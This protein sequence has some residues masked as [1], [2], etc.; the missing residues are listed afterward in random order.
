MTNPRKS[1]RTTASSKQPRG[2]SPTRSA[3][4]SGEEVASEP[5]SPLP[6]K[7]GRSG[8]ALATSTKTTANQGKAKSADREGDLA[9]EDQPSAEQLTICDVVDQIVYFAQNEDEDDYCQSSDSEDDEDD[10]EYSSSK[11]DPSERPPP[12]APVDDSI[13]QDKVTERTADILSFTLSMLQQWANSLTFE[14][15]SNMLLADRASTFT[16]WLLL[17]N[18]SIQMLLEKYLTGIPMAVRA[19][20]AKK[21]K[22]TPSDVA[23]LAE[24]WQADPRPGIYGD[25]PTGEIPSTGMLV[26]LMEAYIGSTSAG[27]KKRCKVHV[28]TSKKRLQDLR[29]DLQRSLHYQLICQEAVTPNIR[30][31]ARFDE[32]IAKGY[33]LLLEAIFMIIF[34]TYQYQGRYHR[35]ASKASFDLVAHIR[36]GLVER[37]DLPEVDWRGLN[38][39]WPV[40]QGFSNP[41]AKSVVSCCNAACGKTLHPLKN[42]PEGASKA[43]NIRRAF[44]PMD[45]LAGKYL[46]LACHMYRRRHGVVPDKRL[47]SD[48][49]ALAD[50]RETAG[51]DPPCHS[52]NRRES[53]FTLIPNTLKNGGISFV[54]KRHLI[55]PDHP[56][57]LLCG[58]C[59]TFATTNGRLR[60]DEDKAYFSKFIELRAYEASTD[61]C[62]VLLCENCGGIHGGVGCDAIFKAHKPTQSILCEPC[63]RWYKQHDGESRDP[64][65][66]RRM[67]RT[68]LNKYEMEHQDIYPTCDHCRRSQRDFT[69]PFRIKLDASG[70]V[71][72]TCW[73]KGLR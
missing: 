23:S 64:M 27:L 55:H 71:C 19:F 40:C 41:A 34:G 10:D 15:F 60:N 57:K 4:V 56:G 52:C 48:V 47:S 65:M 62:A 44:D 28:N 70:S 37:F 73:W 18:C 45:P 6:R 22:W 26:R 68:A 51:P 58:V 25:F 3:D 42:L 61:P 5:E 11:F 2:P 50:A 20:V 32:E 72:G 54:L 21:S 35:Y 66:Q 31:L 67:E 69:M 1:A 36:Q 24:D 29:G 53:T 59:R 39:A 46:C 38:G 14:E 12:D 63:I 13:D 7:K 43:Q 17:R 49:K 9:K 33:L 16:Y 30:V 8:Q